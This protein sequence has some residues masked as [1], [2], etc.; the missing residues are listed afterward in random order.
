M[1]VHFEKIFTS[2]KKGPERIYDSDFIN[3][4]QKNELKMR[5]KVA[6]IGYNDYFSE[7][8]KHHSIPV[9][10][11]EVN[12]FLKSV[13]ENGVI[14]DIGGCWGWHWRNLNFLRPDL[15]VFIVDFV[16]ENLLHAKNIL[17]KQV[18]HSVYLVHGEAT[19]LKFPEASFDAVWTVQV[20]QHIPDFELAVKEAYRV[21]KPSGIFAN[22]SLNTQ[23]HIQLIYRLLQKT[24]STSLYV[25]EKYWLARA[26]IEQKM[27]IEQ[28]FQTIV[29][30]R[31]S[32][33][34]FSPELR[35]PLPGRER[36]LLGQIDKILSN[37]RGLFSWIARQKSFHC[38]K[39]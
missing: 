28:I 31:W 3:K 13:P 39:S 27:L 20:F 4:S 14:L 25:P 16:R 8:S 24:Y 29:Q 34:I 6:S 2:L 35:F 22:Y 37:N 23:P 12:K 32:E 33:I 5:K 10:D 21:L 11:Y 18:D 9:M 7:I 38:Q 15:S 17:Q 36:S 30:E 19:Q 26:S 1:K